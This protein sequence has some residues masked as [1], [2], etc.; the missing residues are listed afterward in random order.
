MK[1]KFVLFI[2]RRLS[3]LLL[4]SVSLF[5]VTMQAQADRKAYDAV[6]DVIVANYNARDY[7]AIYRLFDSAFTRK[8]SEARLIDFLKGNQNSGKILTTSFLSEEK[9]KASYLLQSELRDL[10]LDLQLTGGYKISSFGLRNKPAMLFA[11]PLAVRSNNPKKTALDRAIDTMASEY[12]RNANARSL[13]IGIIKNGRRYLYFYGDR[14]KD[15]LPDSNTLY[16][17]GS[18]TKTFTA[19]VLAHA[20]LNKK[21][22]LADDIRKYLP[23]GFNH[24][25][26]N[27]VPITLQDLAN[28]TSGL[29]AMPP[30]VGDYSD[31]DPVNPDAHYDSVRFFNALKQYSLDTIPGVR[32]SYSN[33]G[34][35]LLGHILEKV[36]G[37]SMD[38][39]YNQFILDPLHMSR[40]SYVRNVQGKNLAYPHS[41]NGRQ[42]PVTDQGYFYPA[43]GLCS[44]VNDMMNYL[45]SQLREKDPAIRLTHQPTVNN[46]GLGWGVVE[47]NGVRHLEHNGSEQGSVAHISV[48]PEMNSGCIVF[49]NAKT[50]L[51][52]V[53]VGIQSVFNL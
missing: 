30:D 7:K 52:K 46:I 19:T 29:P 28:H 25:A 50:N 40:T 22:S 1:T 17:I 37:Q 42:L 5:P 23:A 49:A 8:V 33:W 51:A 48:F 45:D 44:T 20:V 10:I 53:I 16:E 15:L 3:K 18:I 27:G 34:I 43:G 47:K 12:F 26:Y 6:K 4:Y 11:M 35:S 38:V 14:Q 39:L 2:G 36:Y 24:L 32:F 21:V 31:Y 9:G 13:A 41:E